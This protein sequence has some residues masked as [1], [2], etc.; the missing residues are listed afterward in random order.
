MK[1]I[2]KIVFA[3]AAVGLLS[4]SCSKD[5]LE[6]APTSQSQKKEIFSTV[7]NSLRAING[8]HHLLHDSTGSDWMSQGSYPTFCLHLNAMDDDW[9]F[10]YSNTML[11]NDAQ[12]VRHRDLT[13]KYNDINYYWK[14][15]YKVIANANTVLDNIDNI[16]KQTDSDDLLRPFVKGQALAYRA[17]AHHQLV[18]AWAER[19]DWTKT[20]NDQ[21]GVILRIDTKNQPQARES[22]EKVYEQINKDLD[23]AITLLGST[24]YYKDK[25]MNKSHINVW[26]AKGM[27]VRVLM[28]QGKFAE[29]ATLAAEI[30]DNCGAKLD[31]TTYTD[32][33]EQNRFGEASN[34]EWM[35]AC[36]SPRNDSDQY[37]SQRNWHDLTSNNYVSYNQNS[38]RAINCQLF[39]SIPDTDI[40]KTNWIQ[41]PWAVEAAGGKVCRAKNI[42]RIAMFMSQKFLVDDPVTSYTERDVPYMRMPEMA[43][44]AA[45]S[46]ARSGN[47]PKA[48]EYLLKVA[49][50]RDPSYTVETGAVY[51]GDEATL[52]NKIMWQRRVELWGEMGF[53]WLDLKRLN[54]PCDRGLA[55]KSPY[56]TKTWAYDATK[57]QTN[58]DPNASN[59]DRY[60]AKL[61]EAARQIPAGDKRWQWLIPANELAANTLCVQNPL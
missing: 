8:I 14:T 37:G 38:P 6:T 21:L 46:Y 24:T 54:L 43:L 3:I 52:I 56:N 10:T 13:H 60:G 18:Q 49:Q 30:V 29:A 9:M 59:Y 36:I 23:E 5:F 32:G 51:P 20:S 35:W 58:L 16:P 40:R 15:F 25:S 42:G 31:P 55:P 53:R 47:E 26:V 4:T 41:D 22:V 2:N 57:G 19:Y 27:K 11:Q 1:T 44:N 39:W 33:M 28:C 7:N 17:F 48:I 50:D 34:T 12:W 61:G 45:E